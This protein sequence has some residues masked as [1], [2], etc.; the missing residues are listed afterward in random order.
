MVGGR[1][2]GLRDKLAEGLA[3]VGLPHEVFADEEAV[4]PRVPQTSD[5][6]AAHHAR[7]V[8]CTPTIYA[9]GGSLPWPVPNQTR[10]NRP[11]DRTAVA[12]ARVTTSPRRFL[13]HGII[14]QALLD[15][16]LLTAF[17]LGVRP[18]RLY[19]WYNRQK[20]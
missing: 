5:V 4:D 14:R 9:R 10:E 6:V 12:A 20:G 15:C 11:H 17:N 13:R 1:C 18:S 16:T 7:L 19:A 3:G 2:E 8:R